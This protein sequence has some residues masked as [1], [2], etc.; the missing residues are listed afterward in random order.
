MEF[1]YDISASA[2]RT[3]GI[4]PKV[5]SALNSD[6]LDRIDGSTRGDADNAS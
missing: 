3:T 5:P 2:Y 4:P 6:H 1:F